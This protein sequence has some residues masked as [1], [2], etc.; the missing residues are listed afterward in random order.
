M[1]IE[2]IYLAWSDK[3]MSN[4]MRRILYVLLIFLSVPAPGASRTIPIVSCNGIDN[5]E[6]CAI[7][8]ETE[9]LKQFGKYA[10]RKGDKLSLNLLKT[11]LI[12]K[13]NEDKSRDPENYNLWHIYF[14]INGDDYFLIRVQFVEGNSNSNATFR[15]EIFGLAHQCR[16]TSGK[17]FG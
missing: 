13:N 7:H 2:H 12:L 17:C 4:E 3:R 5:S 1:D 10:S 16:I 9:L 6:K 11:S 14:N 8:V 15:A